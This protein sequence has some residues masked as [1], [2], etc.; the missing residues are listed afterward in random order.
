MPYIMT[1]EQVQ[2]L[3]LVC[4]KAC[5]NECEG[6][7]L[8]LGPGSNVCFCDKHYPYGLWI[9]VEDDDDA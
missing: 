8:W 9:L 4:D 5:D 3:G 7:I 6:S 1:S 2:D